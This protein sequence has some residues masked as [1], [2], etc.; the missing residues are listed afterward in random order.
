MQGFD[1]EDILREQRIADERAESSYRCGYAHGYRQARI[2]ILGEDV[3]KAEEEAHDRFMESL[4]ED[5][6][7]QDT[8]DIITDAFDR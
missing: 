6:R 7:E 3:V 2:D 1:A 5:I 8:S 4:I